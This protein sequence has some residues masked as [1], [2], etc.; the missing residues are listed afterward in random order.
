MLTFEEP[1]YL[2]LFAFFPLLLYFLYL[3]PNRGGG[4]PYSYRVWQGKN[5]IRLPLS[6]KVIY[7]LTE[8][9]AW[10]AVS[11]FILALSGPATAVNRKVYIERGMDIM[12][13]LD[14]SPSMAARDFGAE[15]RLTTAREMVKDFI[16]ERE[17]DSIGLVTFSEEAFLKMPP[18]VDHSLLSD[19]LDDVSL[20]DRGDGTAIG[21][22]VALAVLHLSS[23]TASEK[24]ILLITDGENNLGE[25]QPRT[26][27]SMAVQSNI[28][29]YAVGLGTTGEVPIEFHDRETGK[30]LSGTIKSHFDGTLLEEMADISGGGYFYA[31]SSGSLETIFQTINTMESYEMKTKISVEKSYFYQKLILLGLIF[32]FLY[33]FIRRI[34]LGE[35]V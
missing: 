14:Q 17:N 25:I 15:D 1:A 6:L 12:I 22:G 9:M 11:L 8:F 31:R 19:T 4:I 16:K 32:F 33:W 34:V 2:I 3:R 23:S 24:A 29:I 27:A 28:R 30:I 7:I 21:M 10:L 5:T 13:V 35:V 26:A 20:I 18:T